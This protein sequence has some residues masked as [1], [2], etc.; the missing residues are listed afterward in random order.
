MQKYIQFIIWFFCLPIVSRSQT[1]DDPMITALMQPVQLE[2]LRYWFD[3]DGNSVKT[4]DYSSGTYSLNVSELTDGLHTLHFQAIGANN[5]PYGIDSRV[6]LKM[7]DVLADDFLREH[8]TANMIGYWFDEESNIQTTSNLSGIYQLDVSALSDGLHTVHYYVAGEDASPSGI[9]SS[10][11]LKNAEQYI[12]PEPN[13]I[14]KYTYWVNFDCATSQTVLLD[15]PVNPYRLMTLL[16]VPQMPIRSSLFHFQLNDGIPFIYA[17]NTFNIRFYDTHGEYVDNFFDNAKTYVDY[18]VSQQVVPVG[19]LQEI[20]TVNRMGDNEIIWYT[21]SLEKG[22]SVAFKTDKACSIQ[23]FSPSGEEVYNTSGAESVVYGGCHVFESGTFYLALH[24]V[25]ANSGLTFKFDYQHINKYA[26]LKQNVHTVGNGGYTTIDFEG[27]GFAELY[28]IDIYNTEKDSIDC[29][30]LGFANNTFVKPTFDFTN[31]KLGTYDATFHFT[32]GDVNVKDA[33]TVVEATEITTDVK[34]VTPSILMG[35]GKPYYEIV[36]VCPNGGNNTAYGVPVK[37][38]FKAPKGTITGIDITNQE[39]PT[40]A[41]ILDSDELSDEERQNLQQ[42]SN[43]LGDIYDFLKDEWVDESTGQIMETFM[44]LM[45]TT[46][47]PESSNNINIQVAAS[48]TVETEV[49][50]LPDWMPI[51]N[52]EKKTPSIKPEK[53]DAL[54]N[55]ECIIG[56]LNRATGVIST[57]GSFTPASVVTGAVDCAASLTSLGYGWYYNSTCGRGPRETFE[58]NRFPVIKKTAGLWS[59]ILSCVAAMIPGGKISGK[60]A[61]GILSGIAAGGT[62]MSTEGKCDK[63]FGNITRGVSN[64]LYSR[65]PNDIYGYLSPSGSNYINKNRHDLYYTIEFEND[66]QVATAPAHDIYLSNEIDASLFDLSTFKPTR[67]EIGDK[68]CELSGDKNFITTMDLRPGLNIIAQ[69]EGSFNESTGVANWHISGLDPMTMEP[70]SDPFIGVLPINTDGSGVGRLSYDISLKDGLAE[71]TEIPCQA[72]IT[73]DANEPIMTPVWKNIIDGVAPTS[74][75]TNAEQINLGNMAEITVEITDEQSGPWKY[76][77]YVQYGSGA[78][79]LG[80][81]DVAAGSKAKVKVSEGIEHHF[82]SIA[83]DMAGNVEQKEASSESSLNIETI[84]TEGDVNGDGDVDIADAV[85]IVNHVVGKPNTSFN[86]DAADAN[87]D[88]DI[89]IADA[90]HIVNY[91]VGKI[92]VLAPRSE[93]NL[94]EPE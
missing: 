46:I 27:N 12:Q 69:I 15:K 59:P 16:P 93:W 52:I 65:D 50:S 62:F 68:S 7:T 22:D 17:K 60:L 28:R 54:E 39:V 70:I 45:S 53:C 64:I 88:G 91:V 10:I 29:I 94:P 63:L 76:D 82:Y 86:E 61:S 77:V 37:V 57:V 33:I 74:K 79:F 30:D 48:G 34:L 73:F 75:I 67:I 11:F 90:V 5:S 8:I 41:K 32:E 31:V 2:S 83:K 80:A 44:L 42:I 21:I 24:D 35:R 55:L 47:A 36:I 66:E 6:F 58:P 26:V 89:D 13:A 43:Q 4:V 14:T 40:L 78:W 92:S 84:L 49:E 23:L 25:T 85:C 51:Y 9:K 20:Q 18:G 56:M 38:S 72:K 1:I 87:G 19:E 81:E 71:G 3:E